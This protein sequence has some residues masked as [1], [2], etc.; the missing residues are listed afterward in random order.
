[1]TIRV[2]LASIAFDHDAASADARPLG[3]RRDASTA[4]PIPEWRAVVSAT[5]A[6]SP[7]AYALAGLGARELSLEVTLRAEPGVRQAEVRARAVSAWGAPPS[8][9]GDVAART[10]GFA[11]AGDSGPQLFIVRDVRL[12][13]RGVGVH[14]VAWR[15]EARP[16]PGPEPSELSLPS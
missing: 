9:L 11:P 16:G 12:R 3:L 4:L 8:V 1:M 15:W 6:D 5:P 14:D 2:A 7:V 10:V 13:N